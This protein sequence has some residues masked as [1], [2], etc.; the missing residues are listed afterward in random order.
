MAVTKR[1]TK[2]STTMAKKKAPTRRKRDDKVQYKCILG[3]CTA[4]KKVS[5]IGTVGELVELHAKRTNAKIHFLRGR[6]PFSVIDINLRD[7]VPVMKR[8]VNRGRFEYSVACDA[9]S[10]RISGPPSM[11]VD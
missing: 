4:I 10:R 5:R 6:S 11:I 9:C 1:K 8:I 7:G 3:R 2:K